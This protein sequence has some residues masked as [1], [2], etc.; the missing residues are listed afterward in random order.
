MKDMVDVKIIDDDTI[1]HLLK[2]D[3]D[4]AGTN[5][6]PHLG[7]PRDETLYYYPQLRVDGSPGDLFLD[8]TSRSLNV[9]IYMR[10]EGYSLILI[11]SI[12]SVS[13]RHDQ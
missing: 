11:P 12:P 1:P 2:H 4:G 10:N 13:T 9:S 8:L 3:D 5:L 6:D 7:I